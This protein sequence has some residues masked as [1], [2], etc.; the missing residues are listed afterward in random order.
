MITLTQSHL[1]SCLVCDPADDPLDP[2]HPDL[3]LH[4]GGGE[5]DV[6]SPLVTDHCVVV[7][8]TCLAQ[9]RRAPTPASPRT[10]H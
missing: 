7:V 1:T 4:G 9:T 8:A 3:E 6:L 5:A 2:L 10:F